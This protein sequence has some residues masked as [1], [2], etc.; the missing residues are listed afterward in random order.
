MLPTLL[1]SGFIFPIEN[2]PRVLQW[3]TMVMPPRYFITVIKAIMLKGAGMEFIW[4]E[5]LIMA[6]MTLFF[7]L[8]SLKNFKIRLA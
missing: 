4:K 3:L 8:L 7:I 5:S 1:L 6:G 2:M